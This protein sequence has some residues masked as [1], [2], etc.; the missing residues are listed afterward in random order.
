MGLLCCRLKMRGNGEKIG[1]G[2][3]GDGEKRD[4]EVVCG[5][6]AMGL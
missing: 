6:E 2:G 1:C 3:E 5:A 4:W